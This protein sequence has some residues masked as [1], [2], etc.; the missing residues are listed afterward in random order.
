MARAVQISEEALQQAL[1]LRDE[2][3][4]ATEFRMAMTVILMAKMGLN[5]ISTADMVKQ[6]SQ[7][8]A[9][10]LQFAA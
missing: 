9:Q 2:A 7:P 6:G 5:P 8:G 1:K 4:T 3:T 10:Q